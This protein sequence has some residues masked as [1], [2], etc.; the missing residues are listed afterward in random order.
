MRA[1]KCA[2]SLPGVLHRAALS[3]PAYPAH[4]AHP[5]HPAR[6]A[7]PGSTPL[8]RRSRL[9]LLQRCPRSLPGSHRTVLGLLLGLKEG[10]AGLGR[11]R[12]RGGGDQFLA[13]LRLP[14]SQQRFFPLL[15]WKLQSPRVTCFLPRAANIW[16]MFCKV[17]LVQQ[18]N[19]QSF[20]NHFF[21]RAVGKTQ[22]AL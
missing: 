16:Q 14:L 21:F 6:P 3:L 9:R 17:R 7:H 8:S 13:P 5:A 18:K 19:T 2:T 12:G 15:H 22:Q 1:F 10:K 11:V 20:L 4:P